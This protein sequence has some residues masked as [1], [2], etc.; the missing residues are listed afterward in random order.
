MPEWL[1]IGQ[2]LWMLAACA[3]CY[4]TGKYNGTV[5]AVNFLLERNIITQS[6]LDKLSDPD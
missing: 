6:D 3:A 2:I 5:N 4:L 1:D